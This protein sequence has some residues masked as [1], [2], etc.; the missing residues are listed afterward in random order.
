PVPSRLSRRYRQPR[1]IPLLF[2]GTL[3]TASHSS[4]ELV[5]AAGDLLGKRTTERDSQPPG[6]ELLD[7]CGVWKS[8]G[9]QFQAHKEERGYG[10]LRIDIRLTFSDYTR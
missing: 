1:T 6:P 7:G 2:A 8:P 3:H 9:A 4:H 10:L 5:R